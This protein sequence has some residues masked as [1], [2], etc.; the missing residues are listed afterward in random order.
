[1]TGP[2]RT[3]APGCGNTDKLYGLSK[4]TAAC[5]KGLSFTNCCWKCIS[6]AMKQCVAQWPGRVGGNMTIGA[7]K[8]KKISYSNEIVKFT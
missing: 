2:P 1:M 7:W 3:N 4:D 8:T 5:H 6:R